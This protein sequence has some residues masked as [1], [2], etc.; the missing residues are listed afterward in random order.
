MSVSGKI[1]WRCPSNI[2]LVKY[3][4]K[5]EAQLPGN[6]SISMNMENCYTETTVE[7]EKTVSRSGPL[8]RFLFEG[9]KNPL[10]EEKVNQYLDTVAKE[11]PILN[12]HYLK[13][14]SKNSFPH[15]SGIASSASAFGSLALCLCSIEK[16]IKKNEPDDKEFLRRASYFARLGSGSASRSVYGG[17]VLWGET[18]AI[19]GS[20]DLYAIP[21]SDQVHDTFH[22]YYDAVLLVSSEKKQLD[23]RSG[24]ELMETNP[25]KETK[26]G[27]GRTNTIELLNALKSGNVISFMN[28]VENEAAQLHAMFLTSNP[29]YIFIKPETLQIISKIKKYREASN[30]EFCFTLDA[31]PNIHLLYPESIRDK[32]LPFIESE[33]KQFLENGKWID[34]K[35]GEGPIMLNN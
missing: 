3:W 20:S 2:A 7:F 34:D 8:A 25:Y 18:E 12:S 1:T 9:K 4:G 30:L 29:G 16:E 14:H 28:I 21:L 31:G 15:S 26:A 27:L 10:F 32:I 33:L 19:S 24:H 23:S 5:K 6:P 17:W 13:I 22:R 11:M 35:T